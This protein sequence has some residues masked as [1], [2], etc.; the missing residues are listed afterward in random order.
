MRAIAWIG[1]LLIVL[2]VTGLA[3]RTFSY[4]TKED[5]LDLGPIHAT[6]DKEH[7]VFIYPAAGIAAIAI[8]G[9]LVVF[10]RRKV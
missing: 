7:N 6:A 10:G 3:V 2:G 9:L 1:V 4:T 5:V 8:G